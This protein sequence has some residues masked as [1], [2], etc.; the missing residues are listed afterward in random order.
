M[1]LSRSLYG[2]NDDAS[3]WYELRKS[4]FAEASLV[5]FKSTP[6]VFKFEDRILKFYVDDLL[7]FS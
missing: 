3:I 4:Q 1:R 7:V 5:Q 2:M 6:C